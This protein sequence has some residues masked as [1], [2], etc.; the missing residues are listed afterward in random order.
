MCATCAWEGYEN[1]EVFVL[2]IVYKSGLERCVGN[3]YKP[4][5]LNLPLFAWNSFLFLHSIMS[6]RVMGSKFV[7]G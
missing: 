6:I 5:K 1:V 2:Y 7:P 4:V 3:L